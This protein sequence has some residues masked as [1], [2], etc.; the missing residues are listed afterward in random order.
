MNFLDTFQLML[1]LLIP[2][3]IGFLMYKVK[4]VDKS[5]TK[6]VSALL[7]N[8]SLPCS[9]LQSM[10][11]K[12][13]LDEIRKSISLVLIS[14][15]SVIV[16]F[17]LSKPIAVLIEK[18]KRRHGIIAFA[19]MIPNF[20]FTAYP[21]LEKLYDTT[22]V[23]YA[24]IFNLS[25]F[26]GVLTLGAYCIKKSSENDA[27]CSFKMKDLFSVPFFSLLLGFV[28]LFIP[29]EM[30]S[31]VMTT[32]SSMGATTTPL[33]VLLTGLVLAKS[34]N[35]NLKKIKYYLVAFLRL[36]VIP[37]SALFLLRFLGLEGY[38]LYVPVIILA[39]PIA[40]NLVIF[41]ETYEAETAESA[42]YL[43]VSSVLSILTIP[44]INM[45][46]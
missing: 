34:D 41:S 24:S 8:V 35:I 2:M 19:L 13:P 12:I 40:V 16:C 27:D 1:G 32:L 46:L 10:L 7:Y 31:F 14:A 36:I 17:L 20:T 3:G 29:I 15:V 6:G 39:N 30:P 22:A 9:I 4:L 21:I 26:L 11:V 38:Y 18:K 42:S 25:M 45:I 37:V 5:F 28:L 43:L 44:L 33:G 23:F